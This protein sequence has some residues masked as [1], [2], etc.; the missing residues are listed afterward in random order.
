[1]IEALLP[2]KDFVKTIT[3]DNGLEFCEHCA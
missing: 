1:M 3:S 2:Y